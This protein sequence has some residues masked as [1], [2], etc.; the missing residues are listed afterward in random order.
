MKKRKKDVPGIR[1]RLAKDRFL[2]LVDGE[3]GKWL[4]DVRW[5]PRGGIAVK[6]ATFVSK[7]SVPDVRT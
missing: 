3:T 2:R 1:I 5:R 4:A 7:A 6:L